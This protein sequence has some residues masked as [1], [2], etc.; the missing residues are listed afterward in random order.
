MARAN[1]KEI[2]KMAGISPSAIS[3][4]INGK[5]GVSEETRKR[6]LEIIEKTNYKPNLNSRRLL[7]NRTDNIA[8][9][10]EK[11][12][13]PMEHAFNSELNTIILN[14]CEAYG[15]N[16]LFASIK[17]ENGKIIFPNVIS[18]CDVDGV[19]MYADMDDAV[20]DELDRLKIPYILIDNSMPNEKHLCVRT[21]YCAATFLA[22]DYLIQNGHSKIAYIGNGQ[23]VHFNAQTFEG[24]KK[25]MTRAQLSVPFSWIKTE[26]TDDETTAKCI[27]EIFA[28]AN[29]PTA[30]VCVADVYAIPAIKALRE[31]GLN[32]P[33]DV[34][35]AG[36]DDILL[37]KYVYPE[38]TTVR[39]A[40]KQMG[41]AAMEL[42]VKR[43]KGEL[44]ES[45][46]VD[47][48][49]IIIRNSVR[50]LN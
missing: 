31:I 41:K 8:V 37:S 7:F 29:K 35:V 44:A 39:I 25:A 9:L 22:T 43:I 19:I 16:M 49:E 3:I 27:K 48:N 36:I 30:V 13:S 10:F 1:I 21:D 34:S 45:I 33:V 42:L 28:D 47:P 17:K 32:V 15:Y 20:Y 2:A 5:K 18:S 23:L 46:V 12:M 4:V 38:L 40:R 11:N 14:E 6:V 26:A 24:F 50:S